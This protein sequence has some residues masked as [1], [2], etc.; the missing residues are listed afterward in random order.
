MKDIKGMVKFWLKDGALPKYEFN[1]QGK[2]TLRERELDLNQTIVVEVK[3]VGAT[4]IEVPD[5]AKPALK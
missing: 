1:I 5:E 3:D 2:V 4:K